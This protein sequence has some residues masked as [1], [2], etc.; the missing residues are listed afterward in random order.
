MGMYNATSER[1]TTKDTKVHEGMR[2]RITFLGLLLFCAYAAFGQN[3][4]ER[5]GSEIQVW[6]GGGHSV[7]GGTS[8]IG[9]FDAGLRYGWILTAPHGPGFLKGSFEYVVDAV[10]IFLVFQPANTSYGFG[11]NPLGLKWD[12][13]RR[14]RISPYFELGGGT[15]FTTHEVPTGTS[16]VNFTPSAAL[17]F[18]YLGSRMTWSVDARYLHISDAGLS[19]LNPG[20][21]SI[22]V[23][24]GIGVFRHKH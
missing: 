13:V 24:L 10:P 15:L 16:S 9:V 7:A 2:F 18:H 12:F 1:I 22:Q 14:G 8:N 17:G 21:N 23:R 4:P 6:A 3:G 19:G 20:I 11:I 5:G